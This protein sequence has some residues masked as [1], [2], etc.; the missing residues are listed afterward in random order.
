MEPRRTKINSFEDLIQF[1]EN[2]NVSKEQIE[3]LTRETM[4]TIFIQDYESKEE[5]IS[6]LKDFYYQYR[7]QEMLPIFINCN[8]DV[9][10]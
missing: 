2:H 1:I 3:Q 5:M 6:D 8:V 10:E 7:D 4:K 9:E